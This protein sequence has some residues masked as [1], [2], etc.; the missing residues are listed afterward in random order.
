MKASFFT[1][2][3][4]IWL[5]PLTILMS[6]GSVGLITNILVY[7]DWS[8]SHWLF[9]GGLLSFGVAYLFVRLLFS[10]PVSTQSIRRHSRFVPS[11][12]INKPLVSIYWLLGL[13]G[14]VVSLYVIIMIGALGERD[15][16]FN[17]RYSHTVEGATPK[18]IG[19]LS[20]FSFSLALFYAYKG[21]PKLSLVNLAMSLLGTLAFAERTGLL[22]KI[23]AV[24]YI[25]VWVYGFR[26][27]FFLT[28][29]LVFLVLSFVIAFGAGKV[30]GSDSE[31]F[32]VKY[33]GYGVSS[34]DNWIYGAEPVPCYQSVFG[35]ILGGSIDS[36][37]GTASRCAYVP[38]APPGEFNV[39]TY[40]SNPYVV[41]GSIGVY[42]A[43]ALLGLFYSFLFHVASRNQ[44][45]WVLL[46][47][48]FVYPLVMVFYAWQFS[49]TTFV[50][51][52]I[53]LFPLFFCVS[54]SACSKVYK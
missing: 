15:L 54:R 33:I 47:S 41:F 36:L 27:K 29:A 28:A 13:L 14:A 12:R 17:L 1:S 2:K 40:M 4:S 44:G 52:A 46:L 25:F 45:V 50:Y 7:S 20:L 10:V 43:M 34:F 31:F 53:L 5:S 30:G 26:L 49:L 23:A 42:A 35:T 38:G 9:L 8:L 32:L 16:F 51:L 18:S 11:N 48:I 37:I 21:F 6:F 3:N 22:M 19:Y 24:S 39:Y